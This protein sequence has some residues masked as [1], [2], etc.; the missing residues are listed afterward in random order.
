M[1]RL[2]SHLTDRAEKKYQK[3]SRLMHAIQNKGTEERNTP[4]LA[5]PG[6]DV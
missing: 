2:N 4:E 1:Q 6:N 5:G 3:I